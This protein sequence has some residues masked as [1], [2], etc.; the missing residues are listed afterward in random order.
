[1]LT[2]IRTWTGRGVAAR[3]RS[4]GFTL[5]ELLV[6]VAIIG[7]IAA[8]LIP[9]LLDA[10][11]KAKQRRTMTDMHLIG[12]AWMSWLSDVAGGAAAG[13]GSVVVDWTGAFDAISHEDLEDIL[14]PQFASV[15]PEVDPW[16]NAYEFRVV[17]DPGATDLPFGVRSSGSDGTFDTDSYQAQKFVATD[18]S[19]DIVW[20]GG[21][22]VRAPGGIQPSS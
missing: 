20:A 18:Y 9:N 10:L 12:T 15:L 2:Q 4:K 8:I 13:R 7:V 14:V 3:R 17:D 22:F 6:V 1:M 5:I 19:Q 16:R 11:Q 21:Y